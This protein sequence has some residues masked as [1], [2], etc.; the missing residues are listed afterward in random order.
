MK[1]KEKIGGICA[2]LTF[3][4]FSACTEEATY[5]PAQVPDNAQAYFATDMPEQ[6]NLSSEAS[7]FSIELNRAEGGSEETVEITAQDESGLFGIPSKV[8]FA[9][10]E[11]TASI[12]ISYNAELFQYEEYTTITLTIGENFSTPYASSTYTFKAGIPAPWNTIGEATFV[13][14]Y[15]FKGRYKVELQQNEKDENRYRLVDPY[16][17]ALEKEG[18]ATKG[19]SAPYLEFTI[20]PKGSTFNEVTTTMD[21]LVVYDPVNTGF[22]NSTYSEDVYL[23]HPSNVQGQEK[24]ESKWK[25]N[26]VKKCSENDEPQIVSLAPVY[27]C[28]NASMGNDKSQQEGTITIAFPGVDLTDYSAEITY[29]Q[30]RTDKNN[31]SYA[32]AEVTLG[33]DVAAAKLAVVAGDDEADVSAAV[34]AIKSG[35][36]N[37][38]EIKE[39]TTLELPFAGQGKFSIVAVVYSKDG[40]AQGNYSAS[41]EVA[42]GA[43]AIDKYLGDWKVSGTRPAAP[44]WFANFST[45]ITLTKISNTELEVSGIAAVTGYDD[46]FKLSYDEQNDQ[47]IF[48]SRELDS[49]PGDSN[50]SGIIALANSATKEISESDKFIATMEGNVLQF[51]NAPDNTQTWDK[52]AFLYK[53][54]NSGNETKE[55]QSFIDLNWNRVETLR[56]NLPKVEKK[57]F[58]FYSIPFNTYKKGK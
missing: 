11:K 4:G 14:S 33:T 39:S 34:A 47:L 23:L 18:I 49:Y 30:H 54:Y 16:K 48:R 13:D 5:S 32:S 46:R 3:I 44:P 42:G 35:T 45:T 7:S 29:L 24:D 8:T 53:I 19:N 2:L 41:F 43:A 27:I 58:T 17:E 15:I 40:T 20:L 57:E 38:V 28:L 22:Y 52:F 50:K 51:T 36:L 9:S 55:I 12:V 25:Y 21:S 26:I 10:G 6:I 37:S 56:S 1:L 31:Q